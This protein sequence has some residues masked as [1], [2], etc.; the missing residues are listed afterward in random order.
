MAL[1]VVTVIGFMAILG[2]VTYF[3]MYFLQKALISRD[4]QVIDPK[5]ENTF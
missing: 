4:S 1:G 5:P 2:V 3:I